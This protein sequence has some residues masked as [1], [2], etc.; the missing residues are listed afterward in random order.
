MQQIGNQ[1]SKNHLKKRGKVRS[2][3]PFSTVRPY[4]NLLTSRCQ[5]LILTS[6]FEQTWGSC[7]I[8]LFLFFFEFRKAIFFNF[9]FLIVGDRDC[10]LNCCVRYITVHSSGKK[11][12]MEKS[13]EI[14]VKSCFVF[15]TQK[16]Q[17]KEKRRSSK[18]T[19]KISAEFPH[20]FPPIVD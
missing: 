19:G 18:M 11:C 4:I 3:W 20:F 14:P 16:V 12:G 15:S 9:F 17:K 2:Y 1:Q 13:A 8:K 6:D 5:I 7:Y 10:S